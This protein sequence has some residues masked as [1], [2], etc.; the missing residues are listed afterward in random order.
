[1][2]TEQQIES[3]ISI[4]NDPVHGHEFYTQEMFDK[5][6]SK[7]D[8]IILS[9]NINEKT[10]DQ[11]KIDLVNKYIKTNVK[12]RSQ[13]FEAFLEIINKIPEEELIY[14]T[15][16]AA[17]VEGEAMCAGYTEASR[18]LLECLGLKT[19]T[20]LSKL[21]GHNK[22][23]LHYVVAIEYDRGSGRDHYVLDPEREVSC[24]QKGYDFREYLMKMTFI[25]PEETFYQS[26]VG[27]TGVGPKAEAYLESVKPKKVTGKNNVDKL[28]NESGEVFTNG[29]Y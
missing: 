4:I 28:F 21:P 26:K 15:A 12:I 17:L 3:I 22:Q 19:K 18:M 23:L 10:T 5:L 14:R 13:Y 20:L 16:Y 11:E 27:L 6:L 2:L 29:K 8:E 1:M 9:F 25:I 7:I 24:E